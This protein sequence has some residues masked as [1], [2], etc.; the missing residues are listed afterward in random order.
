VCKEAAVLIIDFNSDDIR[1]ESFPRTIVIGAGPVGL[2][3]ATGLRRRGVDV[4]VLESGSDIASSGSDF[5]DGDVLGLQFT[6]LEK[7]GRGLGGGTSEWAGQCLRF[8]AADF[9]AREW[10]RGSGWPLGYDD[11]LPFYSEAEQFFG[12][13]SDRYFARVWR[14]FGLE[15]GGLVDPDVL[16]RFSVFARKPR[17]FERDRRAWTSDPGVWFIYNATVVGLR[18]EGASVYAVDVKSQ[19][20]KTLT[21]PADVVVLCVGAIEAA[22]MLLESTP[23]FPSGAGGGN[24]HVGRHFL[25][26]PNLTIG[27]IK[28]LPGRQGFAGVTRFFSAYHRRGLLF[29][30][31]LVLSADRQ[32]EMRMLNACGIAVFEW[33]PESVTEN[34]RQLQAAVAGQR[35]DLSMASRLARA[36]R[37]P[38]AIART[39]RARLRGASSGDAPRT[40]T[41]RGFAEQDPST[42]SNVSLSSRRDSLGRP[43]AAVD[44]T[45]GELERRT[46]LGLAREVDSYFQRNRIAQLQISESLQEPG[47]RWQREVNDNQHHMGTARMA[48]TECAGVVDRNG[49]VFGLANLY[50]SGGA[51]MPTGSYANPTL[52]MVALGFRLASYLVKSG[53]VVTQS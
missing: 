5:N 4:L 9:S 13:S 48:A 33:S 53:S 51:V 37:D 36:V 8:H 34:L 44:W 46:L 15:P 14:D 1:A 42:T 22:R 25:D 26:H 24:P 10:I 41:L 29:L 20:G 43:L 11:L 17:V 50:V 40:V 7:R 31:R 16:V 30:P 35:F 28:N 23:D 32:R 45:V 38:A 52:T 18:R 47:T 3:V 21:V 49:K 39:A 27:V 12:V 2:A 6:G 19:A